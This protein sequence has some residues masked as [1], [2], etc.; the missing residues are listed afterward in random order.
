M[1]IIINM[2]ELADLLMEELYDDCY[3][4]DQGSYNGYD[5]SDFNE[6][7]SQ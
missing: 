3:D 5:S 4:E 2:N 7:V 1:S 6:D